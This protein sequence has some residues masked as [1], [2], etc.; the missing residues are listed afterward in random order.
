MIGRLI[1]FLA[2]V[3]LGLAGLGPPVLASVVVPVDGRCSVAPSGLVDGFIGAAC[4]FSGE[5]EVLMADGTTKPISE[6]EVGDWVLAEDP[7]TGERGPR[8]VTHLWVHQ[9][10]ITDL[11]IG[12]HAVATTEDHPF[13]N[14]SDGEWQRADALDAGD[15]VLGADGDLLTVGGVDWGSARTTTAYNLTVDDIHTFFVEVGGAHVLVHNSNGCEAV[16]RAIHGEIG[17]EIWQVETSIGATRSGQVIPSMTASNGS[18]TSSS[19]RTVASSTHWLST[20]LRL[21]SARE[22]RFSN[23]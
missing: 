21:I 23:T 11:E 8:E 15:F 7:E 16:A 3:L 20:N 2:A 6:V 18:T 17:G 10:S 12:G 13:W 1:G 5:T 9:D 4:S 22:S 14:Q 19:C